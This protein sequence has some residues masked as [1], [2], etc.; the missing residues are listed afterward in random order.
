MNILDENGGGR[1]IDSGTWD[2]FLEEIIGMIFF[3]G[4]VWFAISIF[5]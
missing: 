2:R 5:N 1:I 4:F 3:A